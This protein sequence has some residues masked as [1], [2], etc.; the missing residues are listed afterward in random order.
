MNSMLKIL[1]EWREYE[2]QLLKEH[3]GVPC[4]EKEGDERKECELEA[5]EAIKRNRE[6]NRKRREYSA[7]DDELKA[8]S[9][10]K[11]HGMNPPLKPTK[12]DKEPKGTYELSKLGKG[13]VDLTEKRKTVKHC[14][15]RNKWHDKDGRFSSKGDARSWSGSNPDDKSDCSYGWS[16]SKGGG[17][18]LAT[19]LPCG[20]EGGKDGKPN[21][22][23]KAE[24]KC[25]D[26]TKSWQ[27]SVNER[28]QLYEN[29]VEEDGTEWIRV[30]KDI[31]KLLLD[32]HTQQLLDDYEAH[33]D[34][35]DEGML[36]DDVNPKQAQYCNRLGFRNF[37]QWLQATN[38][39]AKAEKGNLLKPDVK[40]EKKAKKTK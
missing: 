5:K 17:E 35:N 1:T 11:V 38:N 14:E 24:W 3:R 25:K 37:T 33:L 16:Q 40:P 29:E 39:L 7:N 23:D 9:K 26:K 30:R 21:P 22:N 13:N 10:G 32:K 2:T 12:R 36:M 4:D 8:L 19:K 18:R 27:K 34:E 20:R 28:T 15:P 6:G 31:F